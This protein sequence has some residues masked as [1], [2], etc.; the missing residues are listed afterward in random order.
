[1][2]KLAIA[3]FTLLAAA[4]PAFADSKPSEE[5][6]KKITEALAAAGYTG[7]EMEKE[8]EAT[9]VYEVDDAKDKDGVQYDIKLDKDFKILSVT[10]D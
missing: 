6:A 2:K 10:R 1:M 3:A 7:G 8:T 9:G 4:A 5:E